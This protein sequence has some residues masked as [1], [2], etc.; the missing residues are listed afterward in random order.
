MRIAK[1]NMTNEPAF[2]SGIGLENQWRRCG[3]RNA[4]RGRYDV[5]ERIPPYNVARVRGRIVSRHKHRWSPCSITPR[6][7]IGA[8][9]TSLR[10]GGESNF[11][12]EHARIVVAHNLDIN[13][14]PHC[15]SDIARYYSLRSNTTEARRI[16]CQSRAEPFA[17]A[18]NKRRIPAIV[19][20][21]ELV[22]S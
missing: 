18:T 8:D 22:R 15:N 2:I 4:V 20:R 5:G 12:I 19:S 17:K 21:H 16:V 3:E 13:R 10:I 9:P 6:K 1:S 7:T 11:S 14:N